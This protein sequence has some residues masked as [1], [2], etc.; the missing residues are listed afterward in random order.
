MTNDL[1]SDVD[2]E[3][4]EAFRQIAEEENERIDN[5]DYECP[6]CGFEVGLINTS[7]CNQCGHVPKGER[8]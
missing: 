4:E 1:D 5:G 7:S 6:S 2:D 3:L 8:A